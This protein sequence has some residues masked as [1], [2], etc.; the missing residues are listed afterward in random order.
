MAC[1]GVCLQE[2][3]V[4]RLEGG[5]GEGVASSKNML[6]ATAAEQHL[7]ACF[8]VL[9]QTTRNQQHLPACVMVTT[10]LG[11]EGQQMQ[12]ASPEACKLG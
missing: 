11:V 12:A 8:V 6:L 4:T 3:A 2:E 10:L 1:C 9:C 5:E 7:A